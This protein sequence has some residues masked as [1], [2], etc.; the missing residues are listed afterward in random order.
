MKHTNDESANPPS[1]RDKYIDDEGRFHYWACGL[2][3]VYLTGGLNISKSGTSYSITNI[4][5][6]HKCI[7]MHL[8]ECTSQLNGKELR[9]LRKELNLTQADL[10]TRVGVDVQ[11]VG[12]WEKDETE[13]K[14]ADRMIRMLYLASAQST[15]GNV[16][17]ILD[18]IG[19]LDDTEHK[20]WVFE[21][22]EHWKKV[23]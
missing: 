5:G 21:Q 11:T 15:Q 18:A 12:R 20:Q 3:N 13:N 19:E 6:L 22:D 9:F 8:V 17:S 1:V 7:A 4:E 23:A 2:D 16:I 14:M 10:G